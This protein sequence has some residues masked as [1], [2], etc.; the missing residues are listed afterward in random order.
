[1]DPIIT[2]PLDFLVENLFRGD[3]SV[4][5]VTVTREGVVENL[6]GASIWFTAKED[7]TDLDADA[8]MAYD[9]LSGGASRVTVATPANGVVRVTF[10][11]ADTA[12]APV[13]TPVFADVQVKTAANEIFTA[14]FGQLV[15][16][17]DVTLRTT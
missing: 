3:T 12:L 5:T 4:L 9:N 6:T 10:N 16:R 8:L 7:L 15:F 2:Q 11:P 1:M 13:D 17:A 14:A